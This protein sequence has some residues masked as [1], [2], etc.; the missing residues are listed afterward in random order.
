[1]IEN[2]NL[3]REMQRIWCS[4][5]DVDGL[6]WDGQLVQNLPPLIQD[7]FLVDA[8]MVGETSGNLL[9]GQHF[10]QLR[11]INICTSYL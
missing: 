6:I 4:L 1:M 3:V 7:P 11:N 10:D 5:D 2:T 8:D 9:I